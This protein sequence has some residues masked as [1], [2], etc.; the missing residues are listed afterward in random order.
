MAREDQN[1]ASGGMVEDDAFVNPLGAMGLGA[2]KTKKELIRTPVREPRARDQDEEEKDSFL[3]DEPNPTSSPAGFRPLPSP[4]DV[5]SPFLIRRQSDSIDQSLSL[6]VPFTPLNATSTSFPTPDT[7]TRGFAD[8]LGPSSPLLSHRLQDESLIM[9]DQSQGQIGNNTP[10]HAAEEVEEE[11]QEEE[12]EENSFQISAGRIDTPAQDPPVK[13]EITPSPSLLLLP[14]E[15]TQKYDISGSPKS[16]DGSDS[17]A[18]NIVKRLDFSNTSS[19]GAKTPRRPLG[20][21]FPRFLFLFLFLP[22]NHKC[23]SSLIFSLY[24]SSNCAI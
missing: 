24:Y 11:E 7:S 1:F 2:F 4:M 14:S 13:A 15:G 22:G 3:E 17:P 21:N 10:H 23:Q 12:E 5:S 20:T 18:Q 19:E 9:M 8:L 16:D 6:E